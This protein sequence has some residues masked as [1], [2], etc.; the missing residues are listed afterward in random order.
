MDAAS[1]RL[2]EQIGRE[3]LTAYLATLKAKADVKD[4]SG[5]SGKEIGSVESANRF[6]DDHEE[7]RPA[8]RRCLWC[9]LRAAILAPHQP[10]GQLALR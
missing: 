4:Q 9:A 6:L 8:G 7:R 3:M 5:Q 10:G 2:S 1:A